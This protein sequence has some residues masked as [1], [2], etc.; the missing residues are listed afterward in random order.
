M[1]NLKISGREKDDSFATSWTNFD[2]ATC[3]LREVSK[4]ISQ[5]VEV[6]DY[7]PYL[8]SASFCVFFASG[9]SSF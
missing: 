5:T 6:C 1:Q 7:I 4:L 2:G 8:I 3:Y 9:V